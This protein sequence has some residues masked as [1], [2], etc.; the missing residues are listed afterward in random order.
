M[1][2]SMTASGYGG[3]EEK[4]RTTIQVVDADT[5]EPII[6]ADVHIV[7]SEE[8]LYTDPDGIVEVEYHIGAALA[9]E[10]SY[11][12]YEDRQVSFTSTSAEKVIA[13]KGR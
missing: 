10:V 1:S 2:L 4:V 12:S 5:G 9:F 7:G 6:G 3:N 13:L 11:I 8:V